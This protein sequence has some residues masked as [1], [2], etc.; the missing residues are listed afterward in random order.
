MRFTHPDGFRRLGIQTTDDF[1]RIV[2]EL[3]EQG[4]MRKTDKDRLEDFFSVYEFN[5]AFDK[6]YEID[7]TP[8]FRKK[9]AS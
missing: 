1:G 8:V 6:E 4:E 7:V 3:I 9:I 5:T 2:F